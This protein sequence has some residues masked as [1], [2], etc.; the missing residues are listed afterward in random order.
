MAKWSFG[1]IRNRVLALFVAI[2]FVFTL[3]VLA[4]TGLL[5][6][7]LVKDLV[8]DNALNIVRSQS[9]IISLW[10]DERV[11]ELEQLAN[12]SLV[13]TL[14][15]ESIEPYLQRR[16][17][18]SHDYFLIYFVATPDGNYDTTSQRQAGNILD[19]DYFPKVM[20]GQTVVSEPIISRS[21]DERIIV[22]ATP[23]WNENRTEVKGLFG[24]SIDLVAMLRSSAELIYELPGMS[25]YLVDSRGNFIRHDD[26][27]LIMYGQIQ[28]IYSGWESRVDQSSGSL[29]IFQ[30][31]MSYRMFFQKLPGISDWSV[32]VRVPTTFFTRPVN[33]LI[34]LL[35]LVSVIGFALALWL[36]SWFASTI[37]KPIVELNQVF[38]QGA[39]GNLTVRAEVASSDELGETGYSFNLM[40][41][42]IGT[43]TY[44][45]PLTGLS[46]RQNFLDYL[47]N[48]LGENTTVILAL[49]SIR[50]LSEVKTLFGPKVTDG[51]L[52][53]LAEVLKTVS[54]DNLVMGRMADAEF[55]LIIPSSATGVLKTIDSLDNLLTHPLHFE[56]NDLSVRIFGG[57]SISEGED[58]TADLFY[59]QAQAAL[60]EAEHSSQ[61]QLKLYNPDTH[62]AMVD[63]LRFQTEIHVALDRGQ[64]VIFYQ[65]IVDLSANAIV[66][67]EALIRWEHPAKGLLAPDQFLQVAEQGGFIEEIGKYVLHRVCAQ[68]EEWLK[69]G[70]E[71]GWV[72]VNISANHF[73]SPHFPTLVQSVL[74]R[75]DIPAS[76][77]RIEI[78]EDA[79]LSPTPEV[80]HNFEELKKIGVQVAIDDFGTAYSTLEYLVRYPVETLKIDKAFIDQIDLN[81]RA[82]GL[83]RSIVGM[84]QNLSMRVVAEGVER[85]EQLEL[86]WEMGCDEA[87]GYLFSRPIPSTDF[88]PMISDLAKRLQKS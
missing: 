34:W 54:E 47:D 69:Q 29:T 31:D 38:K 81:T 28:D 75:Y 8:E 80:L 79:M 26:P 76:L 44:Y 71:P 6:R 77:L 48:S 25:L 24:L 86:L 56:A 49:I 55:G 9:H 64:F 66:G 84:G 32:V 41:D 19:R 60:Y 43:M 14:D 5:T 35:V 7:S 45:D 78:T 11:L 1:K 40:M 85:S 65:P 67:K 16:I 82:Q 57:I 52:I 46:N 51:I 2:V 17:E 83:V 70:I 68:H 21:T 36:G 30:D 58:L 13:E 50:D 74:T 15:W 59:Q 20:A 61:E 37:T 39:Q 88:L 3:F 73:R 18:Q 42:T 33:K 53:R 27:S 23:I 12:S 72:A 63:R 10:L 4:T 87:Q 62:H 22:M